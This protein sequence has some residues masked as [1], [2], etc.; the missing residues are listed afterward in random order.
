[1]APLSKISESSLCCVRYI[2]LFGLNS[3]VSSNNG[4]KNRA[5]SQVAQQHSKN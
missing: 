3:Q 1:M 2:V 4:E 5:R